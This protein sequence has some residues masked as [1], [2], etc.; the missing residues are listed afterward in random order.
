MKG[1]K[2][3]QEGGSTPKL[4]ILQ[5]VQTVK[6]GFKLCVFDTRM[7]CL[8]FESLRNNFGDRQKKSS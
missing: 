2:K 6:G 7:G 3:Y 4:K 5:S 1:Y 8:S